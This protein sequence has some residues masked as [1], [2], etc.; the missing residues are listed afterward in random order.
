MCSPTLKLAEYI[1][2]SWDFPSKFDEGILINSNENDTIEFNISIT[3]CKIIVCRN[4][5]IFF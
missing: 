3:F 4:Q 1:L 2:S 5:L